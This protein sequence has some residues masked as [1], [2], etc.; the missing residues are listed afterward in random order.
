MRPPVVQTASA[1]AVEETL[2]IAVLLAACG[3]FLDGSLIWDTGT[4]LRMP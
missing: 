2:G 3:G 1:S 4:F